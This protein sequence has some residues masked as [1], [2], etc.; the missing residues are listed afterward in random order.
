M[1]ELDQRIRA[2]AVYLGDG[3]VKLDSFL[4]H[5]IDTLL[6]TQIG[7][8]LARLLIAAGASSVS[9]VLTAETSGI[10]PALTTAQALGVPMVFARKKRPATLAAECYQSSAR[11]HTKGE[12][13]TLYVSTEFLSRDDR[14]V[15]VDDF[16]GTGETAEALLDL[17]EQSSATL[18]G[19]GY[20]IEKVYEHGRDHMRKIDAPIVSLARIDIDNE[21][22][23][24]R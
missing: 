10:A 4:N 24:L 23:V 12:I 15:I 6:M 13:A 17:V 5:R 2:E 8:E 18:C 22:V 1:H 7:V 9:T 21:Q 14:V 3:I 16:L 11:S 19:I 20:V